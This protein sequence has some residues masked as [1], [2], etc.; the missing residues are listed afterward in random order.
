MNSLTDRK[1]FCFLF[2]AIV[3]GRISNREF[4]LS[5]F[6][7]QDRLIRVLEESLWCSYD[8]YKEHKLKFSEMS[9][10][11]RKLV[12]RSVLFLNSDLNSSASQCSRGVVH[13]LLGPKW[14]SRGAIIFTWG[15][16][17]AHLGASRKKRG[18]RGAL[19]GAQGRFGG[20]QRDFEI[21]EK[22]LVFVAC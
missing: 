5:L 21:V 17:N 13:L 7:T 9:L 15:P 19:W 20:P 4:E 16:E 11:N 14:A 6:N 3:S 10:A 22:L 12:A 2:K 18:S 8:D 1:R